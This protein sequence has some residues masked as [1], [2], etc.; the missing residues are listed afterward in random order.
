MTME[1]TTN[2]TGKN[3]VVITSENHL[4]WYEY[5]KNSFG[6]WHLLRMIT[7]RDL[8]AR[9]KKFIVG[10]HVE[11]VKPSLHDAGLHNVIYCIASW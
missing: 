9:Y 1:M 7:L 11:P 2:T 5:F 4:S 3:K 10:H 8:K 6:Y